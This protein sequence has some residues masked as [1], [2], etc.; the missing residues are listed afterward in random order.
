MASISDTFWGRLF[1]LLPTGDLADLGLTRSS[2]N[3]FHCPH[4]GH[5]PSHLGE[6]APQLVQY[7]TVFKVLA[8]MYI[9]GSDCTNFWKILLSAYLLRRNS[10]S[11]IAVA[12]LTLSD[13]DVGTS[14]GKDGMSSRLS[15]NDATSADI[16]RPSLPI[17]MIPED[18]RWEV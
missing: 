7:Q 16:P 11:V 4:A 1:D 2:T 8:I 10:D 6:S 17:T 14:G 3:V 5:L 9:S 13:S 18:E 15:T 12:I